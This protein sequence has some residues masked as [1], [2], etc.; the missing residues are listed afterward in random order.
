V[1]VKPARLGAL[2]SLVPSLVLLTVACA[3]PERVEEVTAVERDADGVVVTVVTPGSPDVAWLVNLEGRIERREPGPPPSSVPPSPS[4]PPSSVPPSSVP[5]V[6]AAARRL[7]DCAGMTCYRVDGRTLRVERSVDR[8]ASYVTDWEV[9]PDA[10]RGLVS[11][12]PDLGDPAAHLSSRAVAVLPVPAGAG[13]VVFVANGRDGL[14]YRDAGGRWKR[15]GVP[16]SAVFAAPPRLEGGTGLGWTAATAAAGVVL[17]AAGITMVRRRVITPARAAGV[18]ALAVAVGLL[19]RLAA[20]L[21]D[22]GAVPAA[23]YG[24]LIIV[25]VTIGGGA[26]AIA[27]LTAPPDQSSRSRTKGFPPDG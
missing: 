21:P 13:H 17:L 9:S 12:Y 18:G 10:Y 19:A 6:P 16:V 15:L 27:I 14:L 25:A 26:M 22:L 11:A 5:P 2:L 4:P 24:G 20:G 1:P 23:T 3:A 7:E 8:G